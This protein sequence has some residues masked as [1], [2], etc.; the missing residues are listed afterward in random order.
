MAR[1]AGKWTVLS[2]DPSINSCGYAGWD[3]GKPVEVGVL[4]PPRRQNLKSWRLRASCVRDQVMSLVRLHDPFFTVCESPEFIYEKGDRSGNLTESVI[5]LAYLVGSLS[6]SIHPAPAVPRFFLEVT[7]GTW[8]GFAKKQAT[9]LVVNAR[10]GL[11]L[12]H[13][14]KEDCDAA[15]AVGVGDWFHRVARPDMLGQG[16]HAPCAKDRTAV[17]TRLMAIEAWRA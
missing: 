12:D 14:T 1:G 10:Y 5:K 6:S 8:K 16:L 7:P 3:G 2:L 17:L 15:D 4:H 13:E 9:V 11:N